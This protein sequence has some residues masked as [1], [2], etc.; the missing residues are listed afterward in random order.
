M[1][2]LHHTLFVYIVASNMDT[3]RTTNDVIDALGGTKAVAVLTGKSPQ[4]V[5]NYRLAPRF[6]ADTFL[7]MRDALQRI[8]CDAP[9]SLWGIRELTEAPSEG[10]AA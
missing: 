3:L 6:P 4:S 8:G 10:A 9:P 1:G 5:T 7:I 2:G